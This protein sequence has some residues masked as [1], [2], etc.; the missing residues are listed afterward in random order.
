MFQMC[1]PARK[2]C[3]YLS[4]HSHPDVR[5]LLMD[6]LG[7]VSMRASL[8]HLLPA[9]LPPDPPHQESFHERQL[10]EHQ[11][12]S[13]AAQHHPPCSLSAWQ[14]RPSTLMAALS[15]RTPA[16][17]KTR[18]AILIFSPPSWSSRSFPSTSCLGVPFQQP[19]KLNGQK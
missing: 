11:L 18:P 10:S 5:Y 9:P 8:V 6:P 19:L 7:S 12:H 15:L 3:Q 14:L 4:Q 17:G 13:R 16:R 2:D 1:L